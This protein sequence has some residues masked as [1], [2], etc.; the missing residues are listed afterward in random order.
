MELKIF[1]YQVLGEGAFGDVKLLFNKE[2]HDTGSFSKNNVFFT[3][4]R[5]PLALIM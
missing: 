3:F 2:L 4:L 1:L 5:F